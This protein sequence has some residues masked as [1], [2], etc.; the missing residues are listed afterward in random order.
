MA[1]PTTYVRRYLNDP[2][3][4]FT[5]SVE[6]IA[7]SSMSCGFFESKFVFETLS[8][9]V[10]DSYKVVLRVRSAWTCN[11]SVAHPASQVAPHTTE[12]PGMAV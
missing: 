4:H 11:E 2:S 9:I 3:G 5:V 1:A 8:V 12:M 7:I 6:F 10:P